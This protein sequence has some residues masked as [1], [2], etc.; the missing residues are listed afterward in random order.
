VASQ[1]IRI[2]KLLRT[3]RRLGQKKQRQGK[4]ISRNTSSSVHA[5]EEMLCCKLSQ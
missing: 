1:A 5:Y 4:R 2:F 3:M